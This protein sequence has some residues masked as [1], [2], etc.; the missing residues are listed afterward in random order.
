[1]RLIGSLEDSDK[2]PP[3]LRGHSADSVLRGQVHLQCINS[4]L[5]TLLSR[6]ARII[7]PVSLGH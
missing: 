2:L 5:L 1:M 6:E 7:R 3:L 4:G